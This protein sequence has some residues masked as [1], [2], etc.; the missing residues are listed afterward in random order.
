VPGQRRPAS[1]DARSPARPCAH[2]PRSA[3]TASFPILT[4]P[5]PPPRPATGAHDPGLVGA[6]RP[7]AARA[8]PFKLH[9]LKLMPLLLQSAARVWRPD[10]SAVAAGSPSQHPHLISRGHR[11]RGRDQRQGAAFPAQ[12]PDGPWWT[13]LAPAPGRTARL[14]PARAAPERGQSTATALA[15]PSGGSSHVS[16]PAQGPRIGVPQPAPI[17][18]SWQSV[19]VPT[20][21]VLVAQVFDLS[22]TSCTFLRL[23]T[24]GASVIT[25][26][27]TQFVVGVAL[28]NAT[29]LSQL[30]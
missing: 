21:I 25:L 14:S 30:G 17:S 8:A 18:L 16:R 20:R 12:A 27:K 24:L 6:P 1:R 5:L 15:P 23:N 28:S 26:D 13:R 10:T 7:G 9:E 11:P 3:L 19:S 29:C 4:P 22:L 2:R